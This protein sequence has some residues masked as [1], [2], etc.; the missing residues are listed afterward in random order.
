MKEATLKRMPV[1]KSTAGKLEPTLTDAFHMK[2]EDVSITTTQVITKSTVQ[3]DIMININA[4]SFFKIS[5]DIVTLLELTWWQ[6]I[7]GEW[8]SRKRR[9]P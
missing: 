5:Y 1:T 2:T 6:T 9:W 4:A 3:S 7:A 8:K